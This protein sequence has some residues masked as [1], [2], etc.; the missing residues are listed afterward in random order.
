MEV[1]CGYE[2]DVKGFIDKAKKIWEKQ[3]KSQRGAKSRYQIIIGRKNHRAALVPTVTT[4]SGMQSLI[5]WNLNQ[6][7]IKKIMSEAEGVGIPVSSVPYLWFETPTIL[8]EE[9]KESEVEEV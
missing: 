6:D 2:K 9:S 7:D 5:A 3:G 1:I 8:P 4:R